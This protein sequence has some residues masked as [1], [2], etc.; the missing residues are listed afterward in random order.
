M[1]C[2]I[3]LLCAPAA[4]LVLPTRSLA[5]L[6]ARSSVVRHASPC[7]YS[8]IDAEAT[9]ARTARLLAAK[10]ASGLT[11]D[12][13]ATKLELTNTYTVQLLL[14]QAQLKPDTAPKLKAALPKVTNTDLTA[15]QKHFPMRGHSHRPHST[16]LAGLWSSPKRLGSCHMGIA[17][18][19]HCE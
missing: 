10:E 17:R 9:A 14:G 4:A 6:P 18:G 7:M 1:L 11:F 13:L 8:S 16:P 15:M 3:A 2:V 12:E 5:S 19:G